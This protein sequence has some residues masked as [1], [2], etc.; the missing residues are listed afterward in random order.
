MDRP[1]PEE[2]VAP[3]PEPEVV[4]D[5]V[6][7]VEPA[8]AGVLGEF[9]SELEE[10]LG[11]EFL[12]EAPIPAVQVEPKPT[13]KPAAT[14]VPSRVAPPQKDSPQPGRCSS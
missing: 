3:P 8:S 11:D 10:S 7:E 5:A 9:V 1:S 4:D 13:P 2:H 12:S 14:N 6:E